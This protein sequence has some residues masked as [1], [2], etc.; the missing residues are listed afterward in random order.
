MLYC[1]GFWSSEAQEMIQNYLGTLK[2]CGKRVK[3]I[4]SYG[5]INLKDTMR[6]VTTVTETQTALFS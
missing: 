2:E 6:E 4:L 1:K 5:H 3:A